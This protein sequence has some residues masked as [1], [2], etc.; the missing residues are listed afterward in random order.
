MHSQGGSGLQLHNHGEV[1]AIVDVEARQHRDGLQQW[2]GSPVRE[3]EVN[4]GSRTMPRVVFLPVRPVKRTGGKMN[5]CI[6]PCAA[7]PKELGEKRAG[8][9]A[10]PGLAEVITGRVHAAVEVPHD[11]CG[12]L[13]VQ[14]VCQRKH[15]PRKL[16]A[17]HV[18]SGVSILWSI[19]GEEQQP[20][21]QLPAWGK[22]HHMKTTFSMKEP[23][24]GPRGEDRG[25][26]H[27]RRSN[28]THTARAAMVARCRTHWHWSSMV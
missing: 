26:R 8:L 19:D 9:A 1:S 2:Q 14:L 7:Q 6:D 17:A 13:H 20:P 12:L 5:L 28:E 10:A 24:R 27:T 4:A 23:P 15:G 11:E 21:R 18:R 16:L 22:P 3:D 25:G